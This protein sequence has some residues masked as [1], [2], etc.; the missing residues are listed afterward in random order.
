MKQK[1]TLPLNVPPNNVSALI[2]ELLV[3]GSQEAEWHPVDSRFV[4][5]YR[6]RIAQC[7]AMDFI[8]A[9]LHTN[10]PVFTIPLFLCLPELWKRVDGNALVALLDRMESGMVCFNYL[11]FAYKY[12]EVDLLEE[13]LQPAGKC[14]D[15]ASLK[16]F[17][18]S[19]QVG[20]LFDRESAL[21]DLLSG[22]EAPYLRFNPTEWADVT[23]H[24]LH[25]PRLKLAVT[26]Q[27]GAAHLA[28][29]M[30]S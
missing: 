15:M 1:I 10:L 7:S 16:L 6:G 5:A 4:D 23:R 9:A 3:R 28:T 29:L 11:E 20:R 14:Y 18:A 26:G 21:D 12:L 2:H 17:F 13:A 24:L 25:D 30:A 8:V 19:S 22:P 27:Q